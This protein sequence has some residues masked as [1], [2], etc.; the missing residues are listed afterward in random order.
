MKKNNKLFYGFIAASLSVAF[1][2]AKSTASNIDN[3]NEIPTLAQIMTQSIDADTVIDEQRIFRSDGDPVTDEQM[4]FPSDDFEGQT[5]NQKNTEAAGELI[6]A[7]NDFLGGRADAALIQKIE[8]ALSVTVYSLVRFDDSSM[9]TAFT[10]KGTYVFDSE[11]KYAFKGKVINIETGDNVLAKQL[12]EVESEIKTQIVKR[13]AIENFTKF[14]SD[15]ITTKAEIGKPNSDV[16]ALATNSDR[17]QERVT[18][19]H[20]NAKSVHEL[21]NNKVMMNNIVKASPGAQLLLER[22]KRRKEEKLDEERQDLI[23]KQ[24]KNSNSSSSLSDA[25]PREESI[26]DVLKNLEPAYRKK[27][28]PEFSPALLPII[29]DNQFIVYPEN[30]D[31]PYKGTLTVATDFTCPVCK[32]LHNLIPTLNAEGVKVRYMPYPRSK[33]TDYQFSAGFTID[34]YISRTKTEPLNQLGQLVTAGYCS[35]DRNSAYNELFAKRSV[36][37]WPDTITKECEGKAREFKIL[38]DLLFSGSTPY[39]VWGDVNTSENER[40]FIRGLHKSDNS[41]QDLLKRK[42]S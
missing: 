21:A 26:M 30:K 7:V 41:I 15:V 11:I 6:L 16:Q 32:Q 1:L 38:G 8:S 22:D 12:K 35:V 9:V 42:E 13:N 23:V 3:D 40:G 34:Q 5:N 10:T 18:K 17:Q 33:I 24:F 14:S 36:S 27:H 29:P 31:V 19:S 20:F 39:M 25:K 4:I 37:K 28:G 2:G